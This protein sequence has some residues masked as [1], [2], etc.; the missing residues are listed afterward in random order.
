MPGPAARS[1]RG[2]R[3]LRI[4]G[5]LHVLFCLLVQRSP[6]S[7]WFLAAGE[8]AGHYVGLSIVGRFRGS[9]VLS[10][11]QQQPSRGVLTGEPF[12]RTNFTSTT[13]AIERFRNAG[14]DKGPG[15]PLAEHRRSRD[16]LVGGCANQ[17]APLLPIWTRLM[18]TRER[19]APVRREVG[20]F[21][22]RHR[23]YLKRLLGTPLVD[24][25]DKTSSF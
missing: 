13:L 7:G 3:N 18:V 11:P 19:S 21:E 1:I 25:L 10:N 23:G 17:T 8:A 14:G 9:R 16:R 20:Y 5:A 15:L 24:V 4:A 12:A 22:P 2:N 6:R